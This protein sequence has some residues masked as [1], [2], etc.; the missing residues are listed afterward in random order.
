MKSNNDALNLIFDNL[1]RGCC[2]GRMFN[3]CRFPFFDVV[4]RV[5]P[6]YPDLI[7][8]RHFGSSNIRANKRDLLGLIETIFD[9]T[10]ENFVRYYECREL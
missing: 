9:T 6:L 5:N 3:N 8:Y 2:Y 4:L 10:P 1:R 7:Y